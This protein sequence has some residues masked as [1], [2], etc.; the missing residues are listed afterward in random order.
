MCTRCRN[1][2]SVMSKRLFI[3]AAGFMFYRYHGCSEFGN[4]DFGSLSNLPK[5]KPF[6]IFHHRQVLFT[7]M[8][9][10][11]RNHIRYSDNGSSNTVIISSEAIKISVPSHIP[12]MADGGFLGRAFGCGLKGS[13]SLSIVAL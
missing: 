4:P 6:G 2:D 3:A 8:I 9:R 5:V 12:T 11:N 10:T 7:M 1:I 13:L